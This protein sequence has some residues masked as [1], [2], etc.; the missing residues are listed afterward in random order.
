[1]P[2]HPATF[3]SSAAPSYPSSPPRRDGGSSGSG[4]CA[5]AQPTCKSQT[6]W[7]KTRLCTIEPVLP[8]HNSTK[9]PVVDSTWNTQS[10]R[11]C[12]PPLA[13]A[14]R[15]LLAPKQTASHSR[16]AALSL[17]LS[18]GV[19]ASPQVLTALQLLRRRRHLN[20]HPRLAEMRSGAASS[21]P[22]IRLRVAGSGMPSRARAWPGPVPDQRGDDLGGPRHGR[23]CLVSLTDAAACQPERVHWAA[24]TAR[25]S[26]SS[27]CEG[28]PAPPPAACG[29]R[30][31]RGCCRPAPSCWQSLL[32]TAS[33]LR[34][35]RSPTRAR[36][37][38][39][40]HPQ[41]G[42]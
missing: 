19:Q 38:R 37:G 8:A 18:P 11:S 24:A 3:I 1:M 42:D 2:N 29:S 34:L 13:D 32:I 15:R 5:S 6:H 36:L 35:C 26:R 33:P 30:R 14:V 28:W 17:T 4:G 16:H 21:A 41:R 22:H 20:V 12:R 40:E 23:R 7:E 39:A 27:R 10:S 31:Q 25:T 9:L